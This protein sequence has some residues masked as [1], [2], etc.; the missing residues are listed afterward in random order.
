[1]NPEIRRCHTPAERKEA[2]HEAVERLAKGEL[3]GLPADRGY[4][5]IQK[6]EVQFQP[7][8]SLSSNCRPIINCPK[9]RSAQESSLLMMPWVLLLR[10]AEELAD[11]VFPV[12]ARGMRLLSRFPPG[13]VE[14][15][16]PCPITEKERPIPKI[17]GKEVYSFEHI[18]GISRYRVSSGEIL[19]GVHAVSPWPLVSSPLFLEGKI[20]ANPLVESCC[21]L[22][23]LLPKCL[24]YV[25]DAG[26]VEGVCASAVVK[27]QIEG[28]Q[29]IQSYDLTESTVMERTGPCI[30]FVCTGN[31]C[32]SPMAEA[33]CRKLLAQRLQC[34]PE[35]LSDQGIEV[36]SAGIAADFGSPASDEAVVLLGR[37]EV[38]LSDHR[39][40]PL[41]D[42]LLDRADF[43]FAMTNQHREVVLHHRPDLED[44]T[45]V[46]GV[47]KQD[48]PDPIGGG[49]E[50]YRQC[51]EAIVAGLYENLEN[52]IAEI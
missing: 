19:T 13:S 4:V 30:L 21:R 1:M 38:D 22:V 40:Q 43:I 24:N 29:V 36:V 25:I 2:I 20:F 42:E 26:D 41:T 7:E 44:C 5:A 23:N 27:C 32:R 51:K 37:E 46:L 35:A 3:I 8:N 47:R 18:H 49:P 11:F 31:T 48:I 33:I 45:S 34:T 6:A 9:K 15:I 10:C 16:I 28:A 52:L 12:P 17:P 14:L 39:S 50:I